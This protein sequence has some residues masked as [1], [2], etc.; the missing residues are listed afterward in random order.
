MVGRS[1]RR[2]SILR[3]TASV[4]E[5]TESHERETSTQ[6]ILR[7]QQKLERQ[8]DREEREICEAPIDLPHEF[9]KLSSNT[10]ASFYPHNP[11]SVLPGAFEPPAATQDRWRQPPSAAP[12]DSWGAGVRFGG[13]GSSPAEVKVLVAQDGGCELSFLCAESDAVSDKLA[14]LARNS[15]EA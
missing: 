12:S 8:I 11:S 5:R 15:L 1:L 6:A 3:T 10:S 14:Q 7:R 4:V 9:G 2:H 13:N